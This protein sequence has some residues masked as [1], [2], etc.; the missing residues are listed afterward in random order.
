MFE[1][2]FKNIDDVLRE[3][4]GCSTQ[5][6]YIQQTSWMLFLKYLD[7]L[8]ED[9]AAE[10]ALEGKKYSFI[11]DKPYRWEEWAA[12]KNADGQIDHNRTLTGDDPPFEPDEN[13][14]PAPPPPPIAKIV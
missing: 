11:L 12:P 2:A 10:A 5:L 14:P 8:E 6:D 9:K 7:G 3:E 1:Q 4:A 13:D